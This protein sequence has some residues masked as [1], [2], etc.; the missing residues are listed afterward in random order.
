MLGRSFYVFTGI[1]SLL[2]DLFPFYITVYLHTIDLTFS[3]I[4]LFVATTRAGFYLALF[5][6]DNV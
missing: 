1:H 6:W 3:R 4:C 5:V 2:I